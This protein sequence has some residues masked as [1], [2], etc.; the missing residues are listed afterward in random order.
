MSTAVIL[1]AEIYEAIERELK[2]VVAGGIPWE[3][4]L[5]SLIALLKE[6]LPYVSWVGFYREGAAGNLWIGPYQ[7]KLACLKIPP[8]KGVCGVSYAEN[9]VIIVPNVDKFPGHIACD[10][11]SR[12]EIVLPVRQ[13]ASRGVLDLDSH[14]LAAFD[15]ADQRGL[16]R[17]LEILAGA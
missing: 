13:G 4:A 2:G 8:G 7:G 11:L 15:E 9:R 3:S 6:K 16:E 5:V 12:S 10:A 14:A 17:C 1:K